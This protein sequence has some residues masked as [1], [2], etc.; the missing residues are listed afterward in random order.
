MGIERGGDAEYDNSSPTLE[1]LAP[2][3]EDAITSSLEANS[4]TLKL[5]GKYYS[6]DEITFLT[7]SIQVR[8]VLI[9]DLEGLAK[10]MLS[11]RLILTPV[12]KV[13]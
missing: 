8:E 4:T 5:S 2:K 1:E 6:T 3:I 12:L 13:P 10:I 9:L 7:Q 11:K